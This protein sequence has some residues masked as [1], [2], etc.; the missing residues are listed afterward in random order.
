MVSS[1]TSTRR[2]A[3][4]SASALTMVVPRLSA[5]LLKACARRFTSSCVDTCARAC[6]S[7]A[8]TPSAAAV[9]TRSEVVIPRAMKSPAAATARSAKPVPQAMVASEALAVASLFSLRARS[10]ARSSS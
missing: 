10:R 1:K 6:R 3:C 4:F 2:R 9:I 5:I 7:P 8:P